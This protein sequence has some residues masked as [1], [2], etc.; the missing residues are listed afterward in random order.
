MNSITIKALFLFVVSAFMIN[1]FSV[2]AKAQKRIGILMFSEE[3]RYDE[4]KNGVLDQLKEDGFREPAV[5]YTIENARGSKAKLA[6]SVQKLVTAK[7]DLIITIGTTATIAATTVVKDVPVVFS[8][9]YDPVEVGIANDWKSSG[10]NTTGSSTLIP[11]SKIV[12]ILKELA[13]IK[14]LAVLYTPGE[15]NSEAQLIGLQ[16]IQAHARIKVIPIILTRKE[17]VAKTL[18]GVAPTVDAMYLTGSSIIGETVPIIAAIANKAKVVTISHLDDLIEK[19]ALLGVCANSYLVGRLAGKKA[20]KILKGA[21]PS[22]IPIEAEK[23]VDII[24]NKKTAKTG[25]FQIQQDFMKR[26]T[27]T[28]E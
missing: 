2:E 14:R 28:I 21:K 13:P 5:E 8:A 12:N 18:S 10:N 7:S 24:L 6:E 3:A 17:E 19:G 11:M 25:Q 15:K 16:K 4:S 22:S 23:K 1:V 26:V 9:V 27:K 20:G